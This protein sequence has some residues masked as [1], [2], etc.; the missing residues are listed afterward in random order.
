M[1]DNAQ[2]TGDVISLLCPKCGWDLRIPA[3]FA[4]QS[5]T[6][7]RCGAAI[8]VPDG[9]LSPAARARIHGQQVDAPMSPSG[10]SSSASLRPDVG[11]IATEA[12]G[13]GGAWGSLGRMALLLGLLLVIVACVLPALV[14]GFSAETEPAEKPPRR[15]VVLPSVGGAPSSDALSSDGPQVEP[16]TVEGRTGAA[17]VDA[18]SGD[19][20]RTVYVTRSGHRYH[21]AG[22]RHLATGDAGILL[23]AARARG[24]TPCGTCGG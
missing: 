24:L 13:N 2:D 15:A 23:G 5:G 9:G 16:G 10:R 8:H 6:C 19:L 11:M 1:A 22:C 7:N 21:R 4:G 20:N 18:D 12:S 17:L 3:Q 14:I